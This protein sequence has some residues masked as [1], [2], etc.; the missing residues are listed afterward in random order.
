MT[1]IIE[2]PL[3]NEEV[4][5]SGAVKGH[6]RFTVVSRAPAD[7]EIV[8]FCANVVSSLLFERLQGEG[9]NL[10]ITLGKDSSRADVLIRKE[11]DGLNLLWTPKP[12]EP[13]R[14]DE[15]RERIRN[16]TFYI[17]V[18]GPQKDAPVKKDVS[19]GASPSTA[20]VAGSSDDAHRN[21]DAEMTEAEE[22]YLVKQLHRIP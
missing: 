15:T 7:I 11:N 6:V 19:V 17:Q 18:D 3:F 2:T 13:A 9:S 14:L 1:S 10:I 8:G 16:K 4:P 22:D 5:E 20:L 12:M 21:D